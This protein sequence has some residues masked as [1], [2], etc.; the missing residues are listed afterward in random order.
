MSMSDSRA[1]ID[2]REEIDVIGFDPLYYEKQRSRYASRGVELVVLLNGLAAIALLI[3][4]SATEITTL[5]REPLAN[6][7]VVFGAGAALGL[8]SKFFAYLRRTVRLERPDLRVEGRP[9]RWLAVA[10]AVLG[11]ACFIAGL[12]VAREGLI[13]APLTEPATITGPAEPTPGP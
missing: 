8:L 12:V 9:F 4:L 2:I 7:M 13:A 11:A 6:A 10:A 1:E 3:T 5:G